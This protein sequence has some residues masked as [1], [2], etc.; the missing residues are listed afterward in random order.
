MST[1]SSRSD[2]IQRLYQQPWQRLQAVGE[3]S[4]APPSP[5]SDRTRLWTPEAYRVTWSNTL[6]TL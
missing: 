2:S 5:D 1:I 4:A 6:R 3:T